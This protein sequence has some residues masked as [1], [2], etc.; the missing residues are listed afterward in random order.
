MVNKLEDAPRWRAP[1]ELEDVRRFLNTWE[2]VTRT[3]ETRDHLPV[4][5]SDAAGWRR[6]FASVRRPKAGELDD[7]TAL[8]EGLRDAIE[9]GLDPE[10][11]NGWLHA[12]GMTVAVTAEGDG[13]AR[14][15]FTP[16]SRPSTLADVLAIVLGAIADGD[17]LR[18]KACPGC[19]L[20]FFDRTRNASKRWCQMSAREGG[21][22]CGSIAKVRSWRRRQGGDGA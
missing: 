11:V 8:R 13:S 21:R 22:A 17:W 9:H 16:S 10:W 3:R 12:A 14:I 6:R 4:L 19:R 2:Y 15:R 20:V 18:V 5:A 7:L 1:G